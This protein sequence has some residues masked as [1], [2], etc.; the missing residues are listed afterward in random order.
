MASIKTAIELNDQFSGVMDRIIESVNL[1]VGSVSDMQDTL[2]E[3]VDT[4]ALENVR[5]QVNAAAA[6]YQELLDIVNRTNGSVVNLSPYPES[7]PPTATGQTI[8]PQQPRAPPVEQPVVWDTSG[9]TDVFTGTGIDRFR[10]EVQSANEMLQQLSSTQDAIA[11][12]AYDTAIFPA[13]AALDLN[14]MAVRIDNIRNKIQQIGN[15]PVNMGTDA[16]NAGME[17]LRAQLTQILHEQ[18]SLNSAV[19]DLDVSAANAAYMSLAQTVGNTEQYIRDNTDAQGVFNRE[20]ESGGSAMDGLFGK[21]K[22]AVGAYVGIQGIGKALGIADELTQTTARLDMMNSTF[23]DLNGTI[24][25]TSELV[26]MVYAAAQDARGSFDDMAGVVARFGNNARDAFGNQEEVVA[27][28]DLI[29]KQMT[30]AGASTQEAANAELQLS[31]ALG[32][33]VLRGDELNSIFEQA[34]NLIQNIA[35]YLGVPIGQIRE[36]AADGQLSAD[37]VKAAVFAAADDIN[38]KFDSMPMTWGQVWQSMQNTAMIAF[39][40]VLNRISEIANSDM[41]QGFVSSAI[42]GMA[43]LANVAL[44]VFDVMASG[45]AFVRDNWAVIAPI[46]YGLVAV[47]GLYTAAVLANNAVQA[48]HHAVTVVS[49]VLDA[50]RTGVVTAEAAATAGMTEAQL[51]FNASLLACP[52]TWIIIA[53]I[54]VIAILVAL[55]N[56]IAEVTGVTQSGL[57]IIV[58]ALAV[59]GAWIINHVIGLINT[60]ITL[61]INLYNTF[62][63]FAAVFGILFDDPVAAIKATMLSL[64]NYI[65]GIVEAA[66]AALDAVFGS[67]LADAVSGFRGKIQS[68]IDAT[69]ENAGGTA[70]NT[71]NADDYTLN[72]IDYGDAF[73]AGGQLGDGIA[74]KIS[75]FSLSDVF[76]GTELPDV[77]E[78]ASGFEDYYTG[79]GDSLGSIADDTQKI[80]NSVSGTEEN[81]KYIRDLAEQEAVN[82]YTLASVNVDMS[83]MRNEI[84]NGG[85]IDGFMGELT[86]SVNEAIDNMTEGVH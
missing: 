37:V 53:V 82:R 38:S 76:G 55:C 12:K 85:D 35:D 17:Q 4:S 64:F 60:V 58:G 48:A 80:K 70:A 8:A 18:E 16:A 31:Q 7:A 49:T 74:D 79:A 71:L 56:K 44:N 15:N 9:L 75:S 32:S 11:R 39:Q 62:A 52:I 54:A 67:S 61:A 33:G 77:D 27:F 81:L 41:F 2:S 19:A 69:V 84:K 30:I 45:A 72:R 20:I 5:E 1:A 65:L 34:P 83:G 43:T 24:G 51:A 10:Q 6:A 21:I 29:Q 86:D 78:Y 25:E 57:G 73:A 14:S 23:N 22:A 66:A 28:A 13:D 63:N 3:N 36:M 26:N 50:A 59:A 68:E 42:N 40:P 46:I 47:M